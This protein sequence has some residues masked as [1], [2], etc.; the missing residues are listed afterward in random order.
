MFMANDFDYSGKIDAHELLYASR[1]V[2]K[3]NLTLDD[4]QEVC[5]F[6]DR[7]HQGE[8][9]YNLIIHDVA[10]G[11]MSVLA[12]IENTPRTI[13]E[14]RRRLA[15]NP[16]YHKIFY[17]KPNQALESVKLRTHESLL[18]KM[19]DVGG[20]YKSWIADALRFWDPRDTGY[21]TNLDELKGFFRK[22]GV[23]ITTDEAKNIFHSYD[24]DNTGKLKHEY[25][26]RDLTGQNTATDVF[27]NNSK[28][29]DGGGT[30]TVNENNSSAQV[31]SNLLKVTPPKI[32][33]RI[34]NKIK[35]CLE[36]T[37]HKTKGKMKVQ[38]DG[39]DLL[40]GTFLR[41]DS[42][43]TGK[44]DSIVLMNIFKELKINVNESDV[45]AFITWFDNDGSDL[46]DYNTV[47]N[48]LC[49][50]ISYDRSSDVHDRDFLNYQ[51]SESH[52]LPFL[53]SSKAGKSLAS[54]MASYE[55]VLPYVPSEGN[56]FK[57]QQLARTLH[58]DD[59]EAVAS[60]IPV[61][62][63]PG[64]T[65]GANTSPSHL[66]DKERK[67]LKLLETRAISEIRRKMVQTNLEEKKKIVL[68]RL[69]QVETQR[70]E[71]L[72]K[73]SHKIHHN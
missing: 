48:Q 39:R 51:L 54:N 44:V 6:Y 15:I 69:N 7:K 32:V 70:K 67:K 59:P 64:F 16:L 43:N 22:L 23:T 40:H 21:L 68:E 33:K 49:Q 14:S 46:L 1:K 50:G 10:Q 41:Y 65:V 8:F 28:D 47:V 61:L 62:T 45:Q 63:L 57:V 5:D 25:L 29:P 4:A 2:L 9:D 36:I 24:I 73:F 52:L 18:L 30:K 38:L 26:S 66:H 20:S 19:R 11:M 13:A 56:K 27:F 12:F 35:R 31:S 60:S 72:E 17:P 34:I 37:D 55:R 42:N 53:E 71:I 3:L 58:L